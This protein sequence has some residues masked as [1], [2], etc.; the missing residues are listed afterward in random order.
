MSVLLRRQQGNTLVLTLNRPE[1]RN[2]L[3]PELI[4]ALRLAFLEAADQDMVR[5]VVLTGA[6]KAFCSGLDL[7]GLQEIAR[8]STEENRRDSRV[9]AELLELVYS[10]PKPVVAALN[11][12]AVAGGAGLAS[13][14]DV[15]VMSEAA[16]IGYTEARIGFVA[17][18]V[19]VFLVRQVGDKHARDLLLS[20][21]LV[22]AREALGMGLV[23]EVCAGEQVLERAL[24][25]A[26]GMAANAP[27]SLALTKALLAAVPG[28]GLADGLRYAVEVNA[29]S[30]TTDDLAEGV[31]AF[32]EKREPSWKDETP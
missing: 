6:G 2:A 31:A 18:L 15:V 8:R 7:G 10:C 23:N 16:K 25:R 21:R 3:T 4:E 27:S 22:G 28:M 12:H 17:A 24:A 32:L 9:L 13:V 5:A 11:G 29:L 26:E 20:A 1:V 19:G 30:R 14:C